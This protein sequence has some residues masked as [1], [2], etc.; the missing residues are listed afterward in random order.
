MRIFNKGSRVFATA[1]GSIAPGS[2]PTPVPEGMEEVAKKLLANY[3]TELVDGGVADQ[4]LSLQKTVNQRL[5]AEVSSLK[6]QNDKL[7]KLLE[8]GDGGAAL[9]AS[10]ARIEHLTKLLLDA[11]LDPDKAPD[12]AAI[13]P[14]APAAEVPPTPAPTGDAAPLDAAATT[15]AP[16]AIVPP[17]EPAKVSVRN[18][19]QGRPRRR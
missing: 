7:R 10:N 2:K 14:A 1:F 3:P 12:E 13:T 16:A 19:G 17:V 18:A 8:A 4:D 15:E 6:G 5:N 9:A 11:G